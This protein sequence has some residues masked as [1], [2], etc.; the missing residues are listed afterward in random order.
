MTLF[1]I[2]LIMFRDSVLVG[3]VTSC[4][5]SVT[6]PFNCFYPTINDQYRTLSKRELM[7][8]HSKQFSLKMLSL[9]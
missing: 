5:K 4:Q 3:L 9:R 7:K 1:Y 8:S 2:I 6:V